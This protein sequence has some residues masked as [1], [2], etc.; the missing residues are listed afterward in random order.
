VDLPLARFALDVTQQPDQE[1]ALHRF[2]Q[3][4]AAF[5]SSP[6][7]TASIGG[8]HQDREEWVDAL[9]AYDATLALAPTHR[10]ALLGRVVSLS[11]LGRHE[12]AIASAT[13]MIDLGSW[14]MG[15]AHFWRAWNEYHLDA[16]EA[17]RAD[18]DRAKTLMVNAPTYVLSGMIEVREKRVETGEAEFVEAL[19][20]DAGQCEAAALLGTVRA[21]T[22]RWTQALSAFQQAQ[23]CFDL[24]V[25]LRRD[26][27]ERITKGPGSET[28]KAWLIAVQHRAMAEAERHRNDAAQSAAEI[29]K[30]LGPSSH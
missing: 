20:I 23:Q 16:I 18:I 8:L 28:G 13:R 3:L 19:K 9:A 5:P 30:R 12:E 14:L 15:A 26:L 4:R 27:I 1:D 24:T 2:A 11:N 25:R 7:F 6:L 29:Q 21:E 22:R 17:A 10:E